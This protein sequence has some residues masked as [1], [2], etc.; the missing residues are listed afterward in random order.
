MA[1][2]APGLVTKGKIKAEKFLAE[3]VEFVWTPDLLRLKLTN[4]GLGL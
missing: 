1:V 3:K 2:I 4:Q